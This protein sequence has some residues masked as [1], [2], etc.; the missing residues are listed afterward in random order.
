MQHLL[1]NLELLASL[2]H[3]HLNT[4][5]LSLRYL[6]KNLLIEISSVETIKKDASQNELQNAKSIDTK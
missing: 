5:Q 3:R 2:T 6:L 4:T 1:D